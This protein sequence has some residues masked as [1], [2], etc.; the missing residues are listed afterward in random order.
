MFIVY[1]SFLSNSSIHR[2]RYSFGKDCAVILRMRVE[3]AGTIATG[4]ERIL[5]EVIAPALGTEQISALQR[6]VAGAGVLLVREW[7]PRSRF[8]VRDERL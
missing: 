1:E 3:A 8:V 2:V 6:V 7:R 4:L 5:Y